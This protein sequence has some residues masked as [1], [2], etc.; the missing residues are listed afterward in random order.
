M[1]GPQ[2]AGGHRRFVIQIILHGEINL[3]VPL[4]A[5][6]LAVIVLLVILITAIIGL[7]GTSALPDRLRR[8]LV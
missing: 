5:V 8:P 7:P 1:G 3:P 6:F 4:H 2:T